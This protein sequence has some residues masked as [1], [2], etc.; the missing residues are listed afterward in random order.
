MNIFLSNFGTHIDLLS[1]VDILI[2][3]IFLEEEK[4]TIRDITF[5]FSCSHSKIK[6]IFNKYN[7]EYP[8]L[9]RGIPLKNVEQNLRNEILLYTKKFSWLPKND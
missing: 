6:N 2:L 3:K 1:R 9:K 4:I 7:I 5:H 8:N